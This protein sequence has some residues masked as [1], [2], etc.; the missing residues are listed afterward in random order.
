MLCI[1]QKE[2]IFVLA[3]SSQSVIFWTTALG[4]VARQ[5]HMVR[6]VWE[7]AAHFMGRK[8]MR[9]SDWDPPISFKV[10]HPKS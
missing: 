4:P 5:H 3:H 10:M 2:N 1:T 6:T 9:G 7:R 8:Q